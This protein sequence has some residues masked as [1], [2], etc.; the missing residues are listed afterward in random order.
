M[1]VSIIIPLFNKESTVGQ[2]IESALAQ[3][4]KADVVVVNDGSTDGSYNIAKAYGSAINLVSQENRGLSAARNCGILAT[5]STF[6]V[7]LD[8]DDW[9]EPGFV[10]QTLPLMQDASVGAVIAAEWLEPEHRYQIAPTSVG[11]RDEM[12][13]NCLPQTALYRRAAYDQTPGY[14]EELPAFEDWNM[15]LHLLKRGWHVARVHDALFHYR[16]AAG[17]MLT[18]PGRR[19]SEDLYQQIKQLHPDLWGEP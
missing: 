14:C 17:S 12:L 9:L 1:T 10:E 4:G 6:Y 16:I 19:S 7:P 8:A 3:T 11:L 15:W 13:R 2:A 18:A 5:D